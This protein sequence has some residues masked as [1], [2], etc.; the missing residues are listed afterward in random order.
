MN[1]IECKTVIARLLDDPPEKSRLWFE[2]TGLF[3]LFLLD[4]KR[5]T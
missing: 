1:N 4:K 5:F 2:V 3:L